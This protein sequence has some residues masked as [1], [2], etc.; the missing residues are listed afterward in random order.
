M[1]L[2]AMLCWGIF[3]RS[4]IGQRFLIGIGLGPD[5]SRIRKWNLNSSFSISGSTTCNQEL[6]SD[7]I[8]STTTDFGAESRLT[9][10][11]NINLGRLQESSVT[12]SEGLLQYGRAFE[13]DKDNATEFLAALQD[14]DCSGDGSRLLA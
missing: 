2:L 4:F 13:V 5:R 11:P 9:D 8:I 1:F 12:A 10:M 14:D 6:Y 3:T 7:S